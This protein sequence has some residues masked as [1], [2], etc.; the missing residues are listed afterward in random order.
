MPTKSEQQI[1]RVLTESRFPCVVASVDGNNF[2]VY[3]D[4]R[5]ALHLTRTEKPVT[6]TLQGATGEGVSPDNDS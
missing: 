5:G 1:M 6:L 4:R 2:A 3:K